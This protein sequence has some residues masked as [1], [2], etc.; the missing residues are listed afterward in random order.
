MYDNL[1]KKQVS[2]DFK[3]VV[4]YRILNKTLSNIHKATN[5]GLK[6]TFY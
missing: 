6:K 3:S 1:K 5:A 4:V 2:L